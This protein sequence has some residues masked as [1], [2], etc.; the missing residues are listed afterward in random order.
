MTGVVAVNGRTLL[1]PLARALQNDSSVVYMSI[2]S[3]ET[4]TL[5]ASV[6]VSL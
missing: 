1:G 5:W 4:V 6:P 3:G 2:M